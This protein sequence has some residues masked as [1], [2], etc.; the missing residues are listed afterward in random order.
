MS[1]LFGRKDYFKQIEKLTAS[2]KFKEA[3]EVAVAGGDYFY[4]RGEIDKAVSLY[5]NLVES[6]RKSGVNDHSLFEKLYEKVIPLLYE[7]GHRE[8]ALEKSLELVDEKIIL[9]KNEEALQIVSDLKD[10]FKDNEKLLVKEADLYLRN[11]KIESALGVLNYIIA[12]VSTDPKYLELAAQLL[13]KL[14]RTSDAI[15]YLNALIA[16]DP[17]NAFAKEELSKLQKRNSEKTEKKQEKKSA[18]TLT[19]MPPVKTVKKNIEKKVNK[20]EPEQVIGKKSVIGIEKDPFRELFS[21]EIYADAL[22]S[23]VESP[24]LSARKLVGIAENYDKKGK[25]EIADYLYTKAFLAVPADKS[26]TEKLIKF[27][28][29]HNR[30]SDKI[31]VCKIAAEHSD[32][33]GKLYYYVILSNLLPENKNIKMKVLQYACKSGDKE[34][35][36]KYFYE[37]KPD[38]SELADQLVGMIFPLVKNDLNILR[39]LSVTIY[40]M[41][42]KTEVAFKVYKATG[43]LYFN[44]GDKPEGLKWLMRASDIEKLSLEEYVNIAQYI[45]GLSLDTEKDKVAA[46]LSG[47]VSIASPEEKERLYKLILSLKPGNA[48]YIKN[49]A[50]FLYNQGRYKEAALMIEKLILKSDTE[51]I[52]FVW[53][54]IPKTGE[55]LSNDLLVK[56]AELMVVNGEKQKAA[57]VYDILLDRNPEAKEYIVK[58]F[59]LNMESEDINAIIE[60]FEKHKP[61]HSYSRLLEFVLEKYERERAKSPF[62]YHIHFVLG[63]LYFLMERYEEAIASFQFVLRSHRFED[64]MYLFLGISFEKISLFDFALKRYENAL[65]NN[66][67]PLI[68]K[69]AI[70]KAVLVCIKQGKLDRA[71]FFVNKA[72][73][74]NIKDEELDKILSAIPQD[75]DKILNI[76]EI[77]NDKQ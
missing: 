16:V 49:Y 47:Y 28:N 10:E 17:E 52:D 12:N 22:R 67:S 69:L 65:N 31:F 19:K 6:F 25:T 23:A 39:T 30:I 74:L 33:S 45:K 46:A 77:G 41:R 9:G 21:S 51:S 13:L 57:L 37:I 50:E 71:K 34:L 62:D 73:E 24:R 66:T 38:N 64:L 15:D 14:G 20:E 11:G 44:M 32:E 72:T 26:I 59:I 54:K 7:K 58:K 53:S 60:F 29:R 18:E 2:G 48:L 42:L 56:L 4:D 5:I 43:L 40:G 35:A 3:V 70:E 75:D 68:A 1:A 63:F 61:N 36:V 8:K 55:F 76:E 27:Y